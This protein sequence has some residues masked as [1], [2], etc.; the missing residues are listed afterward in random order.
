MN[1]KEHDA[2]FAT[3]KEEE[4][5]FFDHI[6][7][8]RTFDPQYIAMEADIRRASKFVIKRNG[9]EILLDPEITN[10]LQGEARDEC[11]RYI[12][13]VPGGRV[14][15]IGCGSGWLALELGRMG[16]VVDA[17]DISPKAIALAKRMLEENPF[18]SG[19]GE[20]NY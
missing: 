1:I 14:L 15:D 2:Q 5:K 16:Q 11:L 12:A 17:Y 8:L 9:K 13:H 20:I 19:F 4:A 7:D 18:K 6:A 10:I 3:A